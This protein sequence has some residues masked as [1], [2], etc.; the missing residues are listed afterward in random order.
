M[1]LALGPACR[2]AGAAVA[3]GGGEGDGQTDEPEGRLAL[4]GTRRPEDRARLP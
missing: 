1:Q 2:E 3:G 4:P